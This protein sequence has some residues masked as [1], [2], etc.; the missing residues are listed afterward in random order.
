MILSLLSVTNWRIRSASG[1]IRVRP[2]RLRNSRLRR[3]T[4]TEMRIAVLSSATHACGELLAAVMAPPGSTPGRAEWLAPLLATA[5]ASKDHDLRSRA[6]LAVLPDASHEPGVDHLVALASFQD[7]LAG[8]AIGLPDLKEI[9]SRVDRV[10]AFARKT[11]LD[12]GASDDARE[13]ALRVLGRGDASEADIEPLCTLATAHR[14]D[15]VRAAAVASLRRQSSDLV[16]TRL[17]ANWSQLS[18]AM[19]PGIVNLL[20]G[21]ENWSLA[22]LDAIKRNKVQANEISLTDRQ[23]LL[24]NAS[25]S[26]AKRALDVFP[27]QPQTTRSD[28]LKTYATVHDLAGSASSGAELFTKNCSAC[29][30]VQGIGHDIGPNLTALRDKD[31]DY[32]VKNILDP[33]AVV[34]PRFV[35]YII[36]M[37]DDRMISGVIKAE[38]ATNLT[39]AS[40]GNGVIESLARSD[41]KTI[42][43]TSTSMMPEGFEAALPPQKMADL[44]AFLKSSSAPRKEF[45]GNTP[46]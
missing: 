11:A 29:H 8:E 17:L 9:Q 38:T 16:A 44:V 46:T 13:A 18:P 12:D 1:T 20:L 2:R 24:G 41:V 25:A 3:W 33:S 34:E 37:K 28:L 36:T 40:G 39:V 30:L 32:F 22:L 6:M 7:S 4:I 15:R 19:R 42:R 35:N 26:I 27:A 43:A 31:P 10:V 5:A 14:S 45:A 21:R 23:Q